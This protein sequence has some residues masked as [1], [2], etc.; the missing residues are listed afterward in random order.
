MHNSSKSNR[1]IIK[2]SV[3]F[4]GPGSINFSIIM[5]DCVQLKL[6]NCLRKDLPWGF[7]DFLC[8]YLSG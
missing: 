3:T 1:P 7:N 8:K 6:M 4:N 2:F 5:H